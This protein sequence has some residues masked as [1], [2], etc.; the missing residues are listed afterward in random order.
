[1]S[2]AIDLAELDDKEREA[3]ELCGRK[4]L[5][6]EQAAE[7]ANPPVSPNTMQTRWRCARMRLRRVWADIEWINILADTVE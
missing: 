3:V 2:F 5:T 1:M 4:R 6:I 7:A